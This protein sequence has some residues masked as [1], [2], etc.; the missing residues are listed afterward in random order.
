M[1]G[2]KKQKGKKHQERDYPGYRAMKALFQLVQGVVQPQISS[3]KSCGLENPLAVGGALSAPVTRH[4]R[5]AFYY[6][7]GLPETGLEK[8]NLPPGARVETLPK[9]VIRIIF[10]DR[11]GRRIEVLAV[12][13]TSR[14][15]VGAIISDG[16]EAFGVAA[17]AN[18]QIYCTE[19]FKEAAVLDS[20]SRRARLLTFLPPR[21]GVNH[22]CAQS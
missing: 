11:A 22:V 17:D 8:N 19:A 5:A 14:R 9:D 16:F 18:G 3:L 4:R 20:S 7:A 12:P 6:V 21:L 15:N 13:G 10:N 2:H 1:S